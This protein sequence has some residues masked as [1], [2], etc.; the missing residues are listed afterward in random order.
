MPYRMQMKEETLLRAVSNRRHLTAGETR[1]WEQLR[2]KR[3]NGWRWRRQVPI[4]GWIADFYCPK[5]RVAIE[6]DGSHHSDQKG[7]DARRDRVFF[8][9]GI[10]TLRFSEDDCFASPETVAGAISQ[11][12][13]SCV[14][15][16][17]DRSKL[18]AGR[19]ADA[20]LGG[21]EGVRGCE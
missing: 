11:A 13:Q 16:S 6:V 12:L 21:D 9:H 17:S 18:N 2:S 5:A 20:N 10:T 7:E 15:N 8:R 4:L 14:R 19:S 3:L 1:L